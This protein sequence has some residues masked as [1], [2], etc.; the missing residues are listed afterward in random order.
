M[1]GGIPKM[2]CRAGMIKPRKMADTIAPAASIAK[3][4]L[5]YFDKQLTI[6]SI[7]RNAPDWFA[8]ITSNAC[9]DDSPGQIQLLLGQKKSDNQTN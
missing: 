4:L 9:F 1:T 5:G 6:F 3:A 8:K 7:I 2:D